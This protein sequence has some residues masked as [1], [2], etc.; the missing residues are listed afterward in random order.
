[1][2]KLVLSRKTGETVRVG[3]NV[4]VTV[5]R[6]GPNNVRLLFDAPPEINI[7]REELLLPATRIDDAG[8]IVPWR[9]QMKEAV[10]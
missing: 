8:S 3:E 7:V 2:G 6:V 1:V 5:V 4:R 9:S 10:P